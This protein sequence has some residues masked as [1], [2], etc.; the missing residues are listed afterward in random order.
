MLKKTKEEKQVKVYCD[1]CKVEIQKGSW[2]RHIQSKEH[3]LN[4]GRDGREHF[5]KTKWMTCPVCNDYP[6]QSINFKRHTQTI[7][8]QENLKKQQ[9]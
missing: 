6:I 7:K 1:D 5:E 8:H 3:L 9:T 4:I 2:S